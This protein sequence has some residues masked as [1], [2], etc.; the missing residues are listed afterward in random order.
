VRRGRAKGAGPTQTKR[1]SDEIVREGEVWVT[2]QRADSEV[3]PYNGGNR[4]TAPKE[5][6]VP[7][8][9]WT[10]FALVIDCLGG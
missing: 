2:G 9:P 8:L 1:K 4:E 3:G 6:G 5:N 7:V 10:P